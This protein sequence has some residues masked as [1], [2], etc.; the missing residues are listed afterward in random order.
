MIKDSLN[1]KK[2][3][4]A[5]CGINCAHCT[6]YLNYKY[7]GKPD[8]LHRLKGGCSGCRPRD[9]SCAFVKKRCELL[10]KKKYNFVTNAKI[11][12]VNRFRN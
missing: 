9:K 5:P 10:R 3:L 2:E 8:E 11:S 1:N 6:N 12:P 4:I 7:G